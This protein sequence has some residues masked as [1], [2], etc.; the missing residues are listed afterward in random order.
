MLIKFF[1]GRGGG[2]GIANYLVDPTRPGRE[3]NA[4]EVLRGDIDQTRELIDSQDRK[5]TFTTGVIS[6]APTDAPSEKDQMRVMDDFERL[7][8][9]GLERDQYDITWVRHSHT[10]EGRVELHF[11]VPVWNSQPARR[12]IL[13]R[14]DGRRPSRRFATPGT[15]RKDGRGPTTRHAPERSNE[16]S[17]GLRAATPA[18]PSRA[19]SKTG[20]SPARLRT[21]RVW[22]VTILS[23]R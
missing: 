10:G 11:L 1:G 5:W 9:A 22:S 20:L 21:A 14:R 16:H 8:F 2:G 13:R 7:A 15:M 17:S 6:F 12:S 4:P 23:S 3:D 18:R 19:I